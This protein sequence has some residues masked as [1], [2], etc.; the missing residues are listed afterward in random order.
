M[1]TKL[2]PGSSSKQAV[3]ITAPLITNNRTSPGRKI[4]SAVR[5]WFGISRSSREVRLA[6]VYAPLQ[7]SR[8]FVYTVY[9]FAATRMN[10]RYWSR[11]LLRNTFTRNIQIPRT[12]DQCGRYGL[13]ARRN[14]PV[15]PRTDEGNR[16][17]RAYEIEPIS[18]TTVRC[19]EEY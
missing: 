8:S 5:F 19:R 7:F 9:A 13:Q 10:R 17:T 18:Q 6:S 1:F 11:N 14:S 15:G 4:Q 16:K 2:N 3:V 12:R